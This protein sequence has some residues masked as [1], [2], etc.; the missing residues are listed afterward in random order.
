M[1]DL[2]NALDMLGTNHNMQRDR[3]YSGQPH[4]H[5]G[6]RGAT[7]IR[8]VTFRDLRDC[9]IRA[10]CLSMGVENTAHY[11]E[12]RKGEMAV[13]CENDVY[14]LA[15]T[16]DPMAVV[17]NLACELERLMGIYPN[18]PGLRPKAT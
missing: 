10:M 7:E 1:Q 2:A 14:E 17:Q 9:Y 15:G 6:I 18:V 3:P 16:K 5:E 4:T 12:A 11:A 13:L 8:G